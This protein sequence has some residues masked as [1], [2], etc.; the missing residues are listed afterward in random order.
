MNWGVKIT[1]A[2]IVFAI[3]MII[4]VVISI[5]QDV[6]LVAQDYY[7]QE[8]AY[9]SQIERIKNAKNLDFPPSIDFDKEV[10]SVVITFPFSLGSQI[11]AGTVLL[12]RPSDQRKDV[13]AKLTLDHNNQFKISMTDRK[14]G[15]WLVKLTWSDSQKEYYYEK[16]FVY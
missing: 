13:K 11:Q 12:Y 3:I 4:M 1:L 9:E 14:K 2:F 16:Q 10:N 5:N 15:K 7:K 6:N 8:I